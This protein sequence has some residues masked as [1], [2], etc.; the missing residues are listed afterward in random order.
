MKPET[1]KPLLIGQLAKSA[2]VKADTVRFYERSGLLPRPSRSE[3]GYRVYDDAA[4]QRLR[5][6]KKAQSLGFSLDEVRRILSL[7]GQG[8]TTCR[9]VLAIAEATL[10]ETEIKLRDLQKF[11]DSLA[12]NV[13]RWR[14]LPARR[15]CPSEFC[16]LIES[17]GQTP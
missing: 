17:S 16:D 13:R 14:K 4:A 10:A 15:K 9:S 3:A 11:R 6:V 8:S 12:A 2:G 1:K 7:Q 5:F